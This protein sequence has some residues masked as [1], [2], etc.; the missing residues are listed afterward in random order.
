MDVWAIVAVLFAGGALFWGIFRDKSG[1]NK[2]LTGRVSTLESKVLLQQ[3]TLD[4]LEE[5]QDEMKKALK[6][7]EDQ[8]HSL[9][10]KI[11]RILTILEK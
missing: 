5:E 6:S 2:E 9:D 11:E 8:I 7:L 1:D 10:L 4:R 3:S